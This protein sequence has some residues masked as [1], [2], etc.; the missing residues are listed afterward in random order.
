MVGPSSFGTPSVAVILVSQGRVDPIPFQM[1][2]DSTG[3]GKVNQDVRMIESTVS[4]RRE[5]DSERQQKESEGQ[6][7]AREVGPYAISFSILVQT[8]FQGC[9]RSARSCRK[10]NI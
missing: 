6:R 8:L 3:L 2:S 4:Q 5:L 9:G 7:Q 1:K 10:R